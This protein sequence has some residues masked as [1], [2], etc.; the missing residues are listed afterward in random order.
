MTEGFFAGRAPTRGVAFL[1]DIPSYFM[2][3]RNSGVPKT[4]HSRVTDEIA[5]GTYWNQAVFSNYLKL[6]L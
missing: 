6:E 5:C 3:V 4:S 1:S 2:K